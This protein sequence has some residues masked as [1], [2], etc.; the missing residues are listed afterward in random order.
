MF[1]VKN[2]VLLSIIAFLG[3]LDYSLSGIIV[4]RNN[5]PIKYF[6]ELMASEPKSDTKD[7]LEGKADEEKSEAAKEFYSLGL[8]A[9]KEKDYR[10]GILLFN[11]AI[12]YNEDFAEAYAKL[13]ET[14]DMLK[15]DESAYDNYKNC[16]EIINK[17]ELP[18]EEMGKLKKEILRKTEKFRALEEKVSDCDQEFVSSLM[19]LGEKCMR[20]EDYTLAKDIFSLVLKVTDNSDATEYLQKI[21]EELA[22][23]NDSNK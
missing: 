19:K 17:T 14:Y 22:K 15:E 10:K 5:D 12:A 13:G 8:V 1:T 23:E 3:F 7:S 21:K 9:L 6:N 16:I 18:S 2:I 20:E 4:Q 11:K